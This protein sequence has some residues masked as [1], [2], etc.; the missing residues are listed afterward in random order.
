MELTIE[1][2][3][4]TIREIVKGNEGYVYET[5]G[6]SAGTSYCTY[7]TP[8]GA[9]SCIVG[10]VIS[11]LASED[12]E[13]IHK[14]EWY[15]DGTFAINLS[16]SGYNYSSDGAINYPL[17]YALRQAQMVQDSGGTWGQALEAYERTLRDHE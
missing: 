7:S 16:A 8:R 14:T 17:Q 9:P 10:H 13:A 2:V 6:D 1:Q 3:T 12:F 11:R 15:D 5:Q 4:E